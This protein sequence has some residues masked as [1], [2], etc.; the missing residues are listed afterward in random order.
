M[1]GY[2][3][4]PKVRQALELF[5]GL[6][7]EEEMPDASIPAE[8]GLAP[9]Y[10]KAL[11]V[12]RACGETRPPA[13]EAPP[14]AEL[15]QSRFGPGMKEVR[16]V[17]L[18]EIGA[19]MTPIPDEPQQPEPK[20]IEPHKEAEPAPVDASAAPSEGLQRDDRAAV[21]IAPPAPSLLAVQK[22]VT[23]K[24]ARVGEDYSDILALEG[25]RGIELVDAAGTGLS[26]DPVEWTFSGS[27]AE[28]G[29][30]ELKLKGKIGDRPAEITARLAVI[31][32]PKSLWTSFP[33]D[34][35]DQFWKPD[36]D[37]RQVAGEGLRMIA[38]SK[39]GRS[40]AKSGG[41]REDDFALATHGTWHIAAVADGA[42]SARFSRR[43]SRLAVE[44]VTREL[45]ALIDQHLGADFVCP[46]DQRSLSDEAQNEIAQRLYKTLVAASYSALETLQKQA[47]EIDEPVASLSTTLIIVIA[48]RF[49][50][51]W[52]VGAFSIGD[53]GAALLDLESEIVVPL[54]MPDSG[55]YAGQTRFLSKAEFDPAEVTKRLRIATP[56]R[57]T[58]I[59]L[60]SD[61]ITDP[62]LPTDKVFADPAAWQAFWS[63]DLAKEVD[64]SGSEEEVRSKFLTWLD[65]WSPGNHD[66]RTLAVLLP[67]EDA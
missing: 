45:P 8:P 42:G 13:V 63:D 3:P 34:E 54:T 57:F 25:A 21:P 12:L 14:A 20:E 7:G 50:R 30:F 37:F 39:R 40:H 67:R 59:A 47:D 64:F 26:F 1:S 53:G 23:L 65:F 31:A 52:F 4:S 2:T 35:T 28:A 33:S 27:P 48:R 41:F 9:D 24:N 46:G 5:V 58:A 36:E 66:D 22:T 55:E 61:G 32:D 10:R 17:D 51:R 43:G 44:T 15:I 18:T 38:A 11:A 56:E 29:D 49:E 16:K 60:M 6:A 19:M 62:K